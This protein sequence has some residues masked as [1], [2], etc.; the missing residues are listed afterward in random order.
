MM[1]FWNGTS[2]KNRMMQM[3]TQ[4]R[5]VGNLAAIAAFAHASSWRIFRDLASAAG[6][7]VINLDDM[8]AFF[9]SAHPFDL[10]TKMDGAARLERG[11]GGP[12]RRPAARQRAKR[13]ARPSH[14]KSVAAA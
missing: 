2:V 13:E 11:A 4:T 7:G 10:R 9:P 1:T 12:P 6:E 5:L 8:A 3:R 14:G